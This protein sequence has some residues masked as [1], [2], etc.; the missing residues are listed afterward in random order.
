MKPAPTRATRS[1]FM[2]FRPR[3]TKS[4]GYSIPAGVLMAA[5]IIARL[6]CIQHGCSGFVVLDNGLDLAPH[7]L[8]CNVRDTRRWSTLNAFVNTSPV[9]AK[10]FHL[11]RRGPRNRR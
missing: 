11:I 5:L 2:F 9:A 10:A 1:F 6:S 3:S 7:G 8:H 4:L